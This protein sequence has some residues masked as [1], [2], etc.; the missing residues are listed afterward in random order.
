MANVSYLNLA[1]YKF[2]P[3]TGDLKPLRERLRARGQALGLRGTVLLADEGINLFIAGL[4]PAARE[5]LD[6]LRACPGLAELQAKESWSAT[7]P[8]RR[9][10]VRIK[11]EIIAFGVE[12]VDPARRPSRKLSATNGR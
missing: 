1:A 2:A 3:L 8:F 7:Q 9:M 5:F 10:L 4:E 11:R 6:E 12:G